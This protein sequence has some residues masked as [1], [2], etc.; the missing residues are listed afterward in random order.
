MNVNTCVMLSCKSWDP[1]DILLLDLSSAHTPTFLLVF[2][3][4]VAD[5]TKLSS[6][7]LSEGFDVQ[8]VIERNRVETATKSWTVRMGSI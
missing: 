5:F 6:P 4:N 8:E 1:V 3:T 7:R 2:E